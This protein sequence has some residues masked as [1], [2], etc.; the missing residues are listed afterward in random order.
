MDVNGNTSGI[1]TAIIEKIRSL[2]DFKIPSGMFISYEMMF[3]MAELTAAVNREISVYLSRSGQVC[4]VS[5]GSSTDVS[6]PFLRLRRGVSGL[7]GVRCI[8][9]HPGGSAM[10]SSVDIGTL[11]SSRLDA[12]AAIGVS[13]NGRV[14]GLGAAVI[15]E[16]LTTPKLLGPFRVKDIPIA[17]LMSEIDLASVRVRQAVAL[18][19][20]KDDRESAVLVGLNASEHSMRELKRLAST[21]GADVIGAFSKTRPSRDRKFYLGKGNLNELNHFISAKNADMV[22]INDELSSLEQTTLEETLFIKVIDRT[23]LILDIFASH[24]ATKEGRL[25]VELAQL[26]YGISR[27]TGHGTTLSRLGGGIGTRGPGE[28]KLETDRRRMNRRIFELER[29]IGKIKSQR[30][31]RRVTRERSGL[32]VVALA[33]YTN[34]GKSTLLNR[35]SGSD[36]LAE[37]KLFATLDP[38]T[39][40]VIMP[41]GKTVLFSDTVGFVD[42]LPH[43]LV[44]AFEATLEETKLADLVINVIDASDPN[45]I[46]QKRIVKEVLYSLGVQEETMLDVYNKADLVDIDST[47]R[48][49]RIYISAE[50]GQGIQ[51]LLEIIALRLMPSLIEASLMI[52]Y[53]RGD[54]LSFIQSHCEKPEMIYHDEYTEVKMHIKQEHY[55]KALTMLQS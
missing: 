7:S 22:I 26:K 51:E 33:G 24:A 48:S 30:Q 1:K 17:G 13:A 46:D 36:V 40:K 19:A 53:H 39:R 45:F 29:E 2:Y 3:L 6:L 37:D 20:T 50:S 10:P 4:D 44:A 31:V 18:T 47:I 34:A 23:A 16:N 28:S 8:H 15:G 42:K 9:T 25:Q 32:P 27:L 12:M 52:P 5:I 35:L 11:L 21:A 43:D 38:V 55:Q 54:V 49:E 14:T 41:S